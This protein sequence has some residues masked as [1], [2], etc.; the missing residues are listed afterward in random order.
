[1]SSLVIEATVLCD[2][3]RTENNGKQILIGVYGQNIVFPAFPATAPLSLWIR[4][5]PKKLGQIKSELQAIGP[6]GAILLKAN[7]L[8]NIQK[9]ATSILV[10]GPIPLSFQSDGM[11]KFQ[12]KEDGC[13][14]EMLLEIPVAKG[15]IP[16]SLVVTTTA[17]GTPSPP[18]HSR[19]FLCDLRPAII[20][21]FFGSCFAPL[22]AERLGGRVFAII[23][24]CVLDLPRRDLPDH[25]GGSDHVGGTAF[26][27]R[28]SGHRCFSPPL[29]PARPRILLS[30][31]GRRMMVDSPDVRIAP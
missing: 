20:A 2:L 14:W 17:P 27:F 8:T 26:A 19:G 23:R 25:N 29:R 22:M 21:H 15:I 5:M 31:V 7:L 30:S 28:A 11:I 16:G 12:M 4:F 6:H 1:M 9:E 13:D 10:V 18:T 24:L 3:V